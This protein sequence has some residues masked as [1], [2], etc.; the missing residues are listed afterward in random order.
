MIALHPILVV[1]A[2]GTLVCI[3]ARAAMHK[4][5]DLAMF[6]HTMGGYRL[7]P[8]ALL[9]LAALGLLFLEVAVILG[10]IVPVT[11]PFAAAVALALLA[12]Y[13]A[14]IAINLSRG[15]THIDCGCGG[16]GQGLSWYLVARNA[17]LGMLCLV[18][19]AS[20]LP[21]EM[22]AV[23]WL[24]AAAGILSTILLFAGI[25]K[26]IDNWSWLQASNRAFEQHNHE[27]HD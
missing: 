22:T 5:T 4:A 23:A 7:L 18:A 11:R 13:A 6:V 20:L 15:N 8:A 1:I 12:L 27:G 26:L 25:E 10:L 16:A 14:A 2:A 17:V 9:T 24:S 3:F 19:M 21:V